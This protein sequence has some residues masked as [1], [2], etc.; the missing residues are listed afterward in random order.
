MN[1]HLRS[2]CVFSRLSQKLL[3]PPP[4]PAYTVHA[5][6]HGLHVN[7]LYTMMEYVST[8]LPR[9]LNQPHANH[10][11]NTIDFGRVSQ[12]LLSESSEETMVVNHVGVDLL[13]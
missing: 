5:A 12:S 7:T 13:F 2:A 1:I 4:P 10:L 8:V 3:L 11:T 6:V 9:N